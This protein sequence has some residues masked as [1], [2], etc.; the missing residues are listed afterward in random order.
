MKRLW[1]FLAPC[2]KHYRLNDPPLYMLEGRRLQTTNDRQSFQSCIQTVPLNVE[3]PRM[4]AVTAA[5]TGLVPMRSRCR[6]LVHGFQ[7]MWDT[8]YLCKNM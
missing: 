5:R 7:V 1:R 8:L 2:H 4:R 3:P 6:M